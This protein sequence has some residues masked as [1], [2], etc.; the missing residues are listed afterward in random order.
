MT[1]EVIGTF[2]KS[3]YSGQ[4]NNCVEIADTVNNGRAVRD[5]KDQRGPHLTFTYGAWQAFLLGVKRQEF[6][7]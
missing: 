5:S 6:D 7:C 3:S 1:P 4:N 2:V